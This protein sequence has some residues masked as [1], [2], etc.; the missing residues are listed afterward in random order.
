MDI[1]NR[2]WKSPTVDKQ[3]VFFAFPFRADE[4]DLMYEL[5]G[6]AT[7]AAAPYVPGSPQHMRAIRHWAGLQEASGGIA[8]AT[9]EAA[10]VQFGDLHSPYTP[11]PGTLPLKRPEE[12]TIYSWVLNNIWDTNFPTEQGG[13]MRFRYSIASQAEGDIVGLGTRLGEAIASPLVAVAAPLRDGTLASGS[14]CSI[15]RP[16]IRL[17]QVTESA[18][19]GDLLLWLN[20]CSHE[21]ILSAVEFPDLAV[22]SVQL[23]TAFEDR[24]ATVTMSGGAVSVR[25]LPGETRGLVLKLAARLPFRHPRPTDPLNP[26]PEHCPREP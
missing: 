23:A 5:P 8:W 26:R 17:L 1:E 6:G 4:P 22:E 16:E 18:E 19:D 20:N 15:E 12:S 9:G 11:F 3:S 10:L 21:E 14:F 13:E 7:R 2:M 25:L 24:R